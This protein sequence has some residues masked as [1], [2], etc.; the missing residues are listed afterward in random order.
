VSCLLLKED[1][2]MFVAKERWCHVCCQR[3]M[4]SCLLIKE[5][6]VMFVAKGRWCHV[7]C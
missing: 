7:C 4:V 3:K 2:V 5:D 1:G 6:G